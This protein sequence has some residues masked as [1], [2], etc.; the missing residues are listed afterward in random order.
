MGRHT[1]RAADGLGSLKSITQKPL[2][3]LWAISIKRRPYLREKTADDS[4]ALDRSI[5][6]LK[7]KKPGNGGAVHRIL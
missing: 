3:P 4:V 1:A 6:N 2:M 7:T 5:Q